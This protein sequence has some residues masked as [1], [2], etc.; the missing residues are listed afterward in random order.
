MEF[1]I[2]KN[3]NILPVSKNVIKVVD[4]QTEIAQSLVCN[5]RMPVLE[6]RL[7]FDE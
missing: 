3:L 4:S 7:I 5:R 6:K 2:A 1:F